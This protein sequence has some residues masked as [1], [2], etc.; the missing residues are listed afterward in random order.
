MKYTLIEN[1]ADSFKSAYEN[2]EAFDG[3][4]EGGHHRL[5]DAVIF[6]NHGVEILLKSILKKHSPS[7]MFK[8]IDLY[9]KAKEELKKSTVAKNVFDVDKNLQTVGILEALKRVEYLCDIH[10]PKS[11]YSTIIYING[12]RN[13]LMHY[14]VVLNS[15]EKMVLVSKLKLCYE[16]SVTFFE[17]HIDNF[18]REV[19]NSRFEISRAEFNELQLEMWED[20]QR[21]EAMLE[22]YMLDQEKLEQEI[23]G[24]YWDSSVRRTSDYSSYPFE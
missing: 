18:Q 15:T 24:T 19:Q 3:I 5:K 12:I 2:I 17:S 6:L 13:Q 11:F 21:E 20:T 9:L 1:G 8:K 7:L 4:A 23:H 22:Q 14:E 16:E 10:I